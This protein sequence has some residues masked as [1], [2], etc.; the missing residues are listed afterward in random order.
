MLDSNK[1]FILIVC[2]LSS[3]LGLS[4]IYFAATKIEPKFL[5]IDQIDTDFLG[6]TVSTQGTVTSKY[7][8]K[9]GHVFLTISGNRAKI[10]VP[11]F[12]NFVK[13]LDFDPTIIKTKSEI[14]ITGT[15]DEYE[16]QLQIVPRKPSDLKI[17]DGR[18]AD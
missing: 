4:L 15:V 16:G 13:N 10:Q 5:D 1:K 18:Y 3:V 6:K 17:L 7:I 9:G 2:F 12:S 8:S 14:S 11:L